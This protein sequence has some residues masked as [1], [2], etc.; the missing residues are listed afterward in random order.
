MPSLYFKD[1][2]EFRKANN[3]LNDPKK[4][5]DCWHY[6]SVKKL[7]TLLRGI[8]SKNNFYCLN[9]LNFF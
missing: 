8:T 2:L 6:L 1:Q 3:S 5:K 4:E 9:C 7:S